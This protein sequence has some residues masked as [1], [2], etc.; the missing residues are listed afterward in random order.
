MQKIK[1]CKTREVKTPE[2]GTPGSAGIDFFVPD[3]TESFLSDLY[4]NE[5]NKEQM[6]LGK[7]L[8]RDKDILLRGHGRVVIPSG[9]KADLLGFKRNYEEL[10]KG[11]DIA[12]VAKNK[13]GVGSKKGFDRLAELIDSDYQGEICINIVNTGELEQSVF[14]NDKLIQFVLMPIIK[15]EIV[16]EDEKKLFKMSSERGDGGFGH[17]DKNK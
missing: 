16:V 6:R 13:S 10:P 4:K 9:I 5:V 11:W 3:F 8:L 17:T 15:A 1:I 2:Y 14:P 12:L 7:L